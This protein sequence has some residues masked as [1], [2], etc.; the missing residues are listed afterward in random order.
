M[1]SLREYLNSKIKSKGSSLSAEKTKGKKYKS[2]SAAKKA[3]ALYYTNKNGKLMAAV[4][5]EDLKKPIKKEPPVAKSRSLKKPKVA[6]S[7]LGMPRGPGGGRRDPTVGIAKKALTQLDEDVKK[8]GN[9]AARKA[10]EAGKLDSIK[11]R[12]A[13]RAAAKKKAAGASKGGM[14]KKKK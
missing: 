13:K 9:E 12:A 11:E 2:I 5:A 7:D 4:Y 1:A 8:P 10:R 6:K 3:G 14:M